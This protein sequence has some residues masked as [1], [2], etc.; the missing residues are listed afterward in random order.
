MVD[1]FVNIIISSYE[2]V[3]VVGWVDLNVMYVRVDIVVDYMENVILVFI[4][5]VLKIIFY[6]DVVV[7]GVYCDIVKVEW[8]YSGIEVVI[9]FFLVLFCIG[10]EVEV[11]FICVF[12][13]Y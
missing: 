10:I 7:G 8:M 9:Y 3:F 12:V 1:I 5:N 2:D 4:D 13:F 6:N 11:F